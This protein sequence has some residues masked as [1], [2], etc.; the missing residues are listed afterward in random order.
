MRCAELPPAPAAAGCAR[1]TCAA[2]RSA[3][4]APALPACQSIEVAR[5]RPPAAAAGRARRRRAAGSAWLTQRRA[6]LPER[7]RIERRRRGPAARAASRGPARELGG[8]Q[9]GSSRRRALTGTHDAR[10]A[11]ARSAACAAH[12]VVA[13]ER[14]RVGVAPRRAPP[15]GAGTPSGWSSCAMRVSLRNRLPSTGMSPSSG[16]L[17]LVAAST[18]PAAA[19]PAPRSAPSST[20][21]FDSIERLLVVG[22]VSGRSGAGLRRWRPPGR[23]SSAPC[24]SR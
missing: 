22:P 10:A 3:P 11:A 4:A 18:G 23:S 14:E 2:P 9:R 12:Q 15:P 17:L 8:A 7:R 21:T 20:S 13:V 1:R 5:R 6:R 24:R 19:R 16:H